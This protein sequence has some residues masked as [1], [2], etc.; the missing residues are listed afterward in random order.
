[1]GDDRVAMG[2]DRVASAMGRLERALARV[3]SAI[4]RRAA[5]TLFDANESQQ[6][7]ARHQTLRGQVEGAISKIDSLI[8]SAE[9]R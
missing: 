7:H 5:P 6:L 4:A 1:M 3:E 2:N 9:R 8:Q